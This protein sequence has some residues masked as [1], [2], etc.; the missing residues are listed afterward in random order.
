MPRQQ[1][2]DALDRAIARA[3]LTAACLRGTLRLCAA[4]G[5]PTDRSDQLLREA[6]RRA[7]HLRHVRA[8]LVVGRGPRRAAA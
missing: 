1:N 4:L 2:L 5:R 7:E 8:L 3:E 6:E